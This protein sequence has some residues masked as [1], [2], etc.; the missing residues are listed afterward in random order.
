M[1]EEFL[2]NSSGNPTGR[3]VIGTCAKDFG[4]PRSDE[5]A[6]D[7]P[8]WRRS[9]QESYDRYASESPFHTI[10]PIGNNHSELSQEADLGLMY[11]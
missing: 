5:P 4:G 9:A 10:V 2:L 8:P 7:S 1:L 6:D 11:S 3:S